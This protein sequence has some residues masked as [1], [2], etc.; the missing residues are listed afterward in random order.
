MYTG[1]LLP[2][3]Y[4]GSTNSKNI[5]MG[6]TGSVKSIEWKNIYESEK[7]ENKH[8]FKTKILSY[9]NTRKEALVEELR[10]HKLHNVVKNEK[11]M[12]KSL[13]AKNGCFGM[14][15]DDNTKIKM[16]E[17]GLPCRIVM[18][19]NLNNSSIAKNIA[20]VSL[21]SVLLLIAE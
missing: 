1:E 6:Y 21:R 3:W 17:K 16:V 18:R 19:F 20:I 7:K 15:M 13:A 12:N 10:L 2:K 4:I 5:E 8:L 14:G 11:Y 9:H